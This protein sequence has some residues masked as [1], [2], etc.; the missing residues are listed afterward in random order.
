MSLVQIVRKLGKEVSYT[1]VVFAKNT[2]MLKSKKGESY[3][4][5]VEG[6]LWKPRQTAKPN[7]E[8]HKELTR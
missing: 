7:N 5:S 6:H 3:L 4:E 1:D 8:G 2:P